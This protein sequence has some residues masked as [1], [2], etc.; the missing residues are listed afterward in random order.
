MEPTTEDFGK[1]FEE[2][3]KKQEVRPGNLVKGTVVRVL[4]DFALLD[5]GFKSEGQIPLEEFRNLDGEID[6]QEGQE[7][8]VVVESLENDRGLVELSKERADAMHA[9]DDLVEAEKENRTVEGVV[10]NKIKGGMVVNVGGVR[11]FLPGSQIDLKPIKSLDKLIGK[12][13]SFKILKL[14]Q[15]KSNIVLSRRAILEKERESAR[16]D[17]LKNITEGQ[18]VEGFVKNVTDYGAFI[19][20]GGVDGLLHITDMT[21]GRISHPSEILT[22]NETIKVCVLKYDEKTHRVSLGLKQL[23]SDP[24]DIVEEK[25]QIGQKVKGKIVNITDYGAFIEIDEGF[26]GLVHVSEMSWTKKNKHPSKIVNVG[27]DIEAIVLNIDAEHRRI[28]LGMKQILPNPWDEIEKSFPIGQKIK[29]TVKNV[30]DFGVFV[31]LDDEIDGLIHVSDFSWAAEFKHP[32]D[33]YK[34]GDEVEAIIL[35]IDRK[36]ERISLGV[37]HLEGDPFQVIN[38]RYPVGSAA[39]GKVSKI[40]S[41]VISLDFEGDVHGVI[42]M[43]HF[44]GEAPKVGD[45]IEGEVIQIDDKDKGLVLSCKALSKSDQ[46]K[47]FEDFKSKQGDSKATLMDI[48][49]AAKAEE[50]N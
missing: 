49:T 16:E 12:K 32:S 2:S 39:K 33:L 31:G 44:E 26:E 30:T 37:K 48:M 6:V 21:W 25:F 34:K 1:L 14:N 22:V 36:Q 45:E 7:F 24:W 13:F 11:A 19:D 9:W 23:K 4:R 17:F 5:V 40:D 29:G 15:A 20:L 41:K 47:A 27:D 42:P 46:K 43:S 38:S 35:N 8:D 28:S 10:I 50:E 18:V 3:Y